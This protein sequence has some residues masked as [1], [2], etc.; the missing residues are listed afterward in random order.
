MI[1]G[2]SISGQDN[3]THMLAHDDVVHTCSACGARI[4][5]DYIDPNYHPKG[6]NDIH[7]TYD[8]DRIV[9]ERLGAWLVKELPQGIVLLDLKDKKGRKVLRVG[10]VLRLRD[11]GTIRR[12]E[13]CSRCKQ[14]TSVY[15]NWEKLA[16]ESTRIVPENA[17]FITDWKF[18]DVRTLAPMLLCG[19]NT[20]E[21]IKA[22][23][24]RGLDVHYIRE[25]AARG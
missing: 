5:W 2:A 21:Q 25:A 13:W 4:D 22:M 1:I 19:V 12:E 20:A 14:F 8:G 15:G 3:D 16:F 10:N 7:L 23:K 6:A 11:A 9:S 17:L 18:G 24:W